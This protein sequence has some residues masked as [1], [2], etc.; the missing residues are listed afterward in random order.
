[1]R[2]INRISEPLLWLARA[3]ATPETSG[4]EMADVPAVVFFT[5]P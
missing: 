4:F 1:M 5:R 2:P 3:M